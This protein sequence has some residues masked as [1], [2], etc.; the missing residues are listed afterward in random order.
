MLADAAPTSQGALTLGFLQLDLRRL[1]RA[2]RAAR[3]AKDL[4]RQRELWGQREQARSE[5][6]AVMGEAL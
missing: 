2:L 4:E 5:M 3:A 1:D 6:E